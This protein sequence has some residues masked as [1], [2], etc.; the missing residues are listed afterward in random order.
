M[1][2]ADVTRVPCLGEAFYKAVFNWSFAPSQLGIPAD[3]LVTFTVPGGVFPIGGAMRRVEAEE[4][5]AVKGVTK[6]YFYVDDMSAAMGV[7]YA[8]YHLPPFPTHRYCKDHLH[9]HLLKR[10]GTNQAII[11]NGG[12]KVSDA[13]PEG[14]KGW[15]QFFQDSEGNGH[16][17]YTYNK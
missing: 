7:S 9:G 14:S 3:R 17:I 10:K 1:L 11:A 15:F 16:A 2:S 12:K 8:L 13:I 6:L 4:I 5:A